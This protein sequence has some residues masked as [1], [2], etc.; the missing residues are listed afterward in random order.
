M[1]QC[2]V[3][4]GAGF[5]S[6][7][8]LPDSE[9]YVAS[10]ESYWAVN[11]RQQPWCIVQ[12][13]ST[14]QVADIITTLG[15]AGQGAGD[16]HVAIRSGG[17]SV[18]GQNNI[19]H[20]VT[21]DLSMMNGSSYDAETNLAKI[22]P[23]GRWRDGYA[24]LHE[25]GVI[26]IGGRDGDVGVGGFF[27]GGGNTYFMGR[28]GFGCDS[29]SNFEVVLANGSVVNANES[30]NADLWKALRGGG[31]NYGVVT[32]YDLDAIP[33][34]NVSYSFQVVT[35]EQTDA[36]IDATVEF[37]DLPEEQSSHDGLFV[38][39]WTEFDDSP[40]L[41]AAVKVNTD[42]I[43]NSTSF[44][45]FNAIPSVA[46]PSVSMTMPDAANSSQLEGG[47]RGLPWATMF[48]NDAGIARA[49]MKLYAQFTEEMQFRFGVASFSSRLI[50][51]PM[52]TY[53]GDISNRRG[54][55]VLGFDRYTDNS[56]LCIY[57]GFLKGDEADHAVLHGRLA[58][59]AADTNA[60]AR[61]MGGERDFV[62]FNYA[63]VSQD[64]LGS[65][66]EENVRFMK[67]VARKYDPEGFFQKRVSG[68]FKLDRVS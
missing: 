37:T 49:A 65:Y 36:V 11:S 12:P 17:H 23:G 57:G 22:Q 26:G 41:G 67:E 21:I 53:Y 27:L 5:S 35:M 61:E 19:N 9:A 32:R 16:W 14:Q 58:K 28:H 44:K 68:G 18:D 59:L 45:S 48:K 56:L 24:N 60:V 33:S 2:D 10:I 20:G 6:Q 34:K 39:Y 31:S 7:V 50:L 66:G 29:I 42:N 30:A 63:D 8:L 43:A 51:Q 52:A 55:N 38:T 3:L 25:Q 62:Y 1:V 40:M 4:L 15:A 13:H 54:G 46:N 64:P 47:F